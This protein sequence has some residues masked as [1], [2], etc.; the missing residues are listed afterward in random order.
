MNWG[1]TA[2]TG[3]PGNVWIQR[4]FATAA[5]SDADRLWVRIGGDRTPDDRWGRPP[6]RRRHFGAQSEMA[7]DSP[8]PPQFGMR[9]RRTGNGVAPRAGSRFDPDRRGSEPLDRPTPSGASWQEATTV[10]GS[11]VVKFG[12]QVHF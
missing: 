6:A 5:A 4:P 7:K 8:G 1:L 3:L 11:P 10:L 12:A 2:G 9:G